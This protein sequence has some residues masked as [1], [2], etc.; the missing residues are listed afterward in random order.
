MLESPT[1]KSPEKS[2]T[3]LVVPK[4]VSPEKR[5]SRVKELLRESRESAL[6]INNDDLDKMFNLDV[7]KMNDSIVS[8]RKN[9]IL[10]QKSQA[11]L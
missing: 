11:Y 10:E 1:K 9:D 5:M 2:P 8:D 4:S 7:A 3:K 6:V